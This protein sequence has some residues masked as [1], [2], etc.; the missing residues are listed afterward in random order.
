M[1]RALSLVGMALGV[2]LATPAHAKEGDTFR[3]FVS[4]GWFYDS[5]LFRL[6][7][8]ESPGTP[9]P[10]RYSVLSAGLNVDWKPGR[11]EVVANVTKTRVRYDR[12]SMFDSDGNDYKGI[13]NWHLGNRL[14][15]NLGASESLSQSNFDSV[16]QVN[17]LVTRKR[18]FGRADWEFHPRWRIGGGI[19]DAD[20]TNSAPSLA[21]QDVQQQARDVT[22]TYRTPKG[23]TLRAQVRRVDAEYP[24]AQVLQA[25]IFPFPPFPV[26]PAEVADNSYRQTEYNL[27]G[28]WSVSGK[29]KLHGQAGWV[30]RQYENVLRGSYNYYVPQT[31]Q[32]PN[33]SGFIGRLSGDW[34]AT[35]KTLLSFSVYQELGGAQD[36]N[37]SSVLKKGASLNGVWLMREKWRLNAGVTFENRDFKGDPGTTQLQRNDDTFGESL[38]VSYM[39]IQ[40]VSVDVG[41]SAGRR[42]SNKSVEDYKFHMVFAN[43]RADF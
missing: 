19:D 41:V 12:N 28:D 17:N 20:Y 15:G 22:L 9:R 8:T 32:R 1:K 14:S 16:G 11:Q 24:I 38:S 10:D 13:W 5:N 7:D 27:L 2:A 42:D 23:S 25:F 26:I 18:R 33:F 31:K 21:S 40:A 3:P 4:Y 34:Y 29:L 6:A 36:I 43:V 39:P 35:G 30:D 37:A